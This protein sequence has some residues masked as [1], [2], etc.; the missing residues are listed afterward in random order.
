MLSMSFAA[1]ALAEMSAFAGL[2]GGL[3]ETVVV[4]PFWPARP[5]IIQPRRGGINRKWFWMPAHTVFELSLLTAL[6]AGWP[7]HALRTPL[8]IALVS[9]LAVRLWSAFDFIP[10][11]LAF[12]RAAPETINEK[13][14][15]RWT[16]RSNGRLVLDLITCG[17]MVTGLVAAARIA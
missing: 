4:N 11:A 15:L 6:V 3:Y 1:T 9:H 7:E 14:A 12:E 8:L 13:A 17:A 5:E 16:R 10:K 2:G